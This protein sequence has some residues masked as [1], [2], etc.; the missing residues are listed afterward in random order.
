MITVN[1]ISVQFGG[2]LES[3]V[4]IYR[5]YR[6]PLFWEQNQKNKECNRLKNKRES[7]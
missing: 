6:I 3:G 7:L 5:F 1:D 4:D 2:T